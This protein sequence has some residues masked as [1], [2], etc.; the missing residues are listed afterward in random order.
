M[1]V[2][3]HTG[4]SGLNRH[5]KIIRADPQD[6]VHTLQINHDATQVRNHI[7]LE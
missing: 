2:Q 3:L 5:I 6:L 1:G 7:T 4:D